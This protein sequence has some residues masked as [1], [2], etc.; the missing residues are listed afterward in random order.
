MQQGAHWRSKRKTLVL[1]PLR[2]K[3]LARYFE[4]DRDHGQNNLN[5]MASINL[6][7]KQQTSI[8]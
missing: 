4:T 1:T 7:Y 5:T 3:S 8:F 2:L 6:N